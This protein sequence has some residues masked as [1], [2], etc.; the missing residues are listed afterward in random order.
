LPP[1]PAGK[2]GRLVSSAE[3]QGG[4]NRLLHEKLW[5]PSMVSTVKGMRNL[6][7]ESLSFLEYFNYDFLALGFNPDWYK[8]SV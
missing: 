7:K 6:N 8:N 3:E 1:L 4:S 2:L 5:K